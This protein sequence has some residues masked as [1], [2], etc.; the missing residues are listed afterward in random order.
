MEATEEAV[1]NSMICAETTKGRDG[2]ARHS[3]KEYAS[4]L[5]TLI[6]NSTAP[7]GVRPTRP[8]AQISPPG[9]YKGRSGRTGNRSSQISKSGSPEDL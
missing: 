1:L 3:L 9:F 6:D 7:K 2:N 8:V 5:Y 4:F